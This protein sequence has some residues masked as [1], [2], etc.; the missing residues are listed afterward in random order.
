MS[1]FFKKKPQPEA[2]QKSLF[3][4]MQEGLSRSSSKISQGIS[5]I[6][7][8]KKLDAAMLEQLEELLVTADLGPATAAK[9]A[10]EVGKTR[11]DKEISPEE[12]KHALATE[13]EDILKPAEK[14]LITD[15]ARPFVILMTGVNGSGKTTTMGKLAAQFV[16]EGK[17]V[18]LAAGDTFR[19]AAVEQLK[20]WGTR[21]GCEVISKEEGADAAALAFEAVDRA[22]KENVDILMID[23]AGR[24]QNK[25]NLM[26]ELTKIVRVIKKK[27]PDAPHAALLVLDATVGQNAHSQV[28][29]F[30]Q[31]I[32]ITGLVVTKLDGTAKGGVVVSLVEKFGLPIQALGLGEAIEDLRPF[33][34][35]EYARSIV[36]V[37]ESL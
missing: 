28:E 22:M 33:D 27:I 37:A 31:A 36:G 12:I 1:W 29:L 19:A 18:L 6:F 25:T 30:R 5:D 11:F 26:E 8:K 3:K 32:N 13:I 4:K 24:L 23:T 2:E 10:A 9:L 21:A 17:T 14:P 35:A 34:A 20:V 7:T 16:A 15:A